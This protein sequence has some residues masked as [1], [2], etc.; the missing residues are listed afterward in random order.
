MAEIQRRGGPQ[1]DALVKRFGVKTTGVPVELGEF[2]LPVGEVPRLDVLCGGGDTIAAEAAKR[3]QVQLFNPPGSGV[4]VILHRIWIALSASEIVTLRMHN[5]ALADAG[6]FTPLILNRTA[7]NQPQPSAQI[8]TLKDAGLG[9]IAMFWP[10]VVAGLDYR[11]IHLER[12]GAVQVFEGP[13]LAEGRGFN[14]VPSA[15]N[16][17]LTATFEWSER[18]TE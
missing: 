1:F 7:G 11:E 10:M 17:G 16:I 2:I 8:R 4:T 6:A 15:D 3:S 18:I 13:S 9:T 5:T 14:I 12:V